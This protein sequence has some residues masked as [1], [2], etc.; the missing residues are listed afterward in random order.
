MVSTNQLLLT[1]RATLLTQ[2]PPK[3]Q[4]P[5]IL[6][7]SVTQLTWKPNTPEAA[8]DIAAQI[9]SISGQ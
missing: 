8:E 7:I 3:K 4:I 6:S 5:G 2:Q 1:T 9:A